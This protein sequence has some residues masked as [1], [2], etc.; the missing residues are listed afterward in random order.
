[1]KRTLLL[2]CLAA[3]LFANAEDECRSS[4]AAGL[5]AD[6]AELSP[7]ADT[8]RPAT[9]GTLD[10]A[11]S[12]GKDVSLY[13]VVRKNSTGAVIKKNGALQ[14]QKMKGV[15]AI[16]KHPTGAL[17]IQSAL[18]VDADG[19]AD[20]LT[21]DPEHGQV[22]TSLRYPGRKGQDKYV[23]THDIP[24]FVLPLGWY[25]QHGVKL[26]DVG[27]LLY[28]G[29]L[30]YAIFADVGPDE[31]LGEGSLALHEA[32]GNNPWVK[33]KSGVVKP[34]GGIEG[35]VTLVVFPGSGDGTPQTPEA[36]HRIGAEELG[37]LLGG[38]P[39]AVSVAPVAERLPT[40][41]KG[42]EGSD[43]ERLQSALQ[44]AGYYQAKKVDGD[45]GGGTTR[46]VQAF[47][48][49]HELNDDGVVGKGTW[50]ALLEG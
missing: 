16:R 49:D 2:A 9:P 7:P 10:A 28:K 31:K 21:V 24:F 25:Q 5:V 46:A 12:S 44:Q 26:G 29:E 27:A 8:T 6:L 42:A 15:T 43:V 48:R 37:A 45:F 22:Q 34:W 4:T 23:N 13:S 1:M 3:P 35:G 47:Q 41:R 38:T 19:S 11:F 40:L 33:L 20:S 36:V 50:A 14:Y 32:L 30:A 39:Q 17:L 18:Q